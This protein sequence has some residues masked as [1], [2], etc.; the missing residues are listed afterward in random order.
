V[1][2]LG[3]EPL[4]VTIAW[5][6]VPGSPVTASLDPSD[7]MLVNDLDL[8]VTQSTNIYFP[9]KLDGANPSAAATR[10]DENNVDNVEVVLIE[11]P[12]AGLEYTIVVDHD[13]SL[14]GGLQAFSLVVSGIEDPDPIPPVADFAANNTSPFT[15]SVVC[16]TDQSANNPTTWS[17]SF[18]PSTVTFINGTDANSR[19]PQI[20]F[21]VAGTYDVTLTS[22]NSYGSDTETKTAYIS[23]SD[24]LPVT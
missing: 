19:N 8:R 10:A 15:G 20:T 9:W 7:A 1:K 5:T 18:S 11:N 3:G 23:V 13:G 16:F 21:D 4:K 12:V 22:S 17:W 24:P 14:N 6:D 2:A